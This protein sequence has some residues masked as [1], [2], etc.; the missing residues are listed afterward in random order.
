MFII[1]YQKKKKKNQDFIYKLFIKIPLY[2]KKNPWFS[3]TL[4][5]ISTQQIIQKLSLKEKK[6]SQLRNNKCQTNI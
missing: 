3:K 5:S 4:N 1:A 2:F 6:K